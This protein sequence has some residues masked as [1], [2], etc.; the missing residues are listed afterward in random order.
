MD[1]KM[2]EI[3]VTSSLDKTIQP[4]LFYAA[5]DRNRP[6]L[7]GLHTW[8]MNR[9]NQI[10]NL[11]PVARRNDW[12]LL[13]PEFRGANLLENP[14]SKDACASPKAKQDVLDA[15]E[16]V[17]TNYGIDETNILLFGA[18]GGGHMA[19]ML[20]AYAPKLWRAICS[21]VPITDV[22]RWYDENPDYRESIAACCGDAEDEKN[23]AVYRERSPIYYTQEIAKAT[24]KIY[25][26][27]WDP[28]VPCHHG[29][30]LYL[31]IFDQNP[32]AKVYFEMF[33][34]GHEMLIPEAEAWLK[35]HMNHVTNRYTKVTG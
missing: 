20:A 22:R 1:E 29:L 3:M 11:L 30:D 25:S 14:N 21:F 12:N 27:K 16:Y 8:G 13:L 19:L 26:G 35:A 24:V 28:I 9:L 6:L 23:S 17:K 2:Q 10:E 32:E 34:G 31:R 18:S 4:N 5:S 33:D 15:I 7:V